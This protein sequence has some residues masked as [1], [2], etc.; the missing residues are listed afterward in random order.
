[1]V[2]IL[3]FNRA[4]PAKPICLPLRRGSVLVL[5]RLLLVP[6]VRSDA[7]R[8]RAES[9]LH[10]ANGVWTFTSAAIPMGLSL[11]VIPQL[12]AQ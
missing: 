10:Q 6:Q 9:R 4:V 1:M 3:F 2:M 8:P 11:V 5:L 7:Q 12:G